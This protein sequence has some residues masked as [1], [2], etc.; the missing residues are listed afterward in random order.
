MT[1]VLE[2]RELS[3]AER[4][5]DIRGQVAALERAKRDLH[6]AIQIEQRRVARAL[7]R[8]RR[9]ELRVTPRMIAI[10]LRLHERGRQAAIAEAASMGATLRRRFEAEPAP[11]P[12]GTERGVTRL[13]LLLGALSKRLVDE[14][15]ARLEIDADARPEMLRALNGIPGALDAAGRVVSMTLTSGLQDVYEANAD[16]FAGWEY[17]AVLDGGTCAECEA[18][19]GEQYDTLDEGLEVLPNFGPNPD[20]YGEDRCRCRLLPAGAA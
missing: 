3:A 2:R 13:R 16:A 18:H 12:P 15:A 7:I 8:G 1:N 4:H 10:L 14:H 17:T 20:C 6:L 11:P 9:V 5:M 19:D